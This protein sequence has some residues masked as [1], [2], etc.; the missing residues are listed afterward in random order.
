MLDA[1]MQ[2]LLLNY[3]RHP[4]AVRNTIDTFLDLCDDDPAREEGA[5]YMAILGKTPSPLIA[6][7]LKEE[8]RLQAAALS[9]SSSFS[10]SSG[11]SFGRTLSLGGGGEEEEGGR[12]DGANPGQCCVIA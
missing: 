1:Y 12:D 10:S 5:V 9:S 2:S 6:P 3:Y 7:S 4:E 8:K 11:M